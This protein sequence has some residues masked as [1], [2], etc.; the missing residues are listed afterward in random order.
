MTQASYPFLCVWQH[1]SPAF[2]SSLDDP[3]IAT[4]VRLV[5]TTKWILWKKIKK[6]VVH[7][8]LNT[9][10]HLGFAHNEQKIW[11]LSFKDNCLCKGQG[12]GA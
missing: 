10:F 7:I 9:V 1:L 11:K 2:Q 3:R 4:P 6:P 8:R 5:S 12:E